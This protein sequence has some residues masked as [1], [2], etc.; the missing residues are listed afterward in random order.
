MSRSGV[1]A[2]L[3]DILNRP[4]NPST[5]EKQEEKVAILEDINNNL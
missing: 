1:I 2:V 3:V 4:I 5:V